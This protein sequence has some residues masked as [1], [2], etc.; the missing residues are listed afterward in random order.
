MMKLPEKKKSGTEETV[1]IEKAVFS[2]AQILASKKYV[3]RV[4]LLNV[5]LNNSKLYALEEVDSLIDKFMKG[6]VK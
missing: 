3:G 4:D 5:L 6:K 1:L 2:K